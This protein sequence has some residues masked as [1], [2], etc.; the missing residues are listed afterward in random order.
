MKAVYRQKQKER[1]LF[2]F[3]RFRKVNPSVPKGRPLQLSPPEP[4]I[5]ID[6]TRLGVEVT[7]FYRQGPL[8][9]NESEQERVLEK[10]RTICEARGLP[11][12][13]VK[14]I[15]NLGAS[16]SKR[17]RSQLANSLVNAVERNVPC[18]DTQREIE[19][20]EYNSLLPSTVDILRIE[21]WSVHRTH[22]WFSPR[23]DFPAV[24]SVEEIQNRISKKNTLFLNYAGVCA[25]LW[26]LI[27]AEG[28][29]PSSWSELPE[30][31]RVH[32]YETT[33]DRV[34]FFH[35]VDGRVI[36]LQTTKT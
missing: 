34:F 9:H 11:P 13:I 6:G 2:F 12:M 33:F 5:V 17:E 32:S 30:N 3:E 24:S 22:H 28:I 15:W 25:S 1:E 14:V 7:E 35:R 31:A 8:K 27:V 23:F 10:A 20:D 16:I 4:D 21:R 29:A 36:E 26:L 19:Q 18:V